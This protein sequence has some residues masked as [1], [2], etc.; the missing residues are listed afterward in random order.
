MSPE[1]AI[2]LQGPMARL[3]EAAT[4]LRSAGIQSNMVRPPD[5]DPSA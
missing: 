5:G 4:V 1:S 3:K 2:L